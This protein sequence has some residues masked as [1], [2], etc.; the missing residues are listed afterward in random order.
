MDHG[1]SL[2]RLRW[3]ADWADATRLM[4]PTRLSIRVENLLQVFTPS[5]D[6]PLEPGDFR[7]LTAY[8]T[9]VLAELA[10]YRLALDMT[11]DPAA[12]IIDLTN[13]SAHRG[14]WDGAVFSARIADA[15]LAALFAPNAGSLPLLD[16]IPAASLH[17]ADLRLTNL[18]LFEGIFSGWVG[19]IYPALGDT[20]EDAVDRARTIAAE[21]LAQI[22]PSLID[23][24]SRAALTA[25]LDSIP[26]PLG[27]LRVTLD[28]PDGIAPA[29]LAA[30][31]AMIE[32]PGWAD[33]EG[34]LNGASLIARWTPITPKPQ[35]PPEVE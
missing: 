14:D 9:Q 22:P 28:A 17:H 4:P 30:A 29:R 23:S 2:G 15:D 32:Q 13:L 21:Q 26:H 34:M 19:M 24:D 33:I 10:P 12:Q 35:L 8:Q 1:F 18:G 16:G 7:L 11:Y 20:P 5:P 6:M 27:R 31:T 3:Q 25:V